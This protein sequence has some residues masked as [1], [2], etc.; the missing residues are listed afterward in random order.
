MMAAREGQK[1]AAEK[2]SAIRGK[3]PGADW[4]LAYVQVDHT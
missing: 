2:Y 4:P 1:K 3:F